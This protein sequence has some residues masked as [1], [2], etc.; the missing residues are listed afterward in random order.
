MTLASARFSRMC[1]LS[2]AFVRGPIGCE[3]SF[4]PFPKKDVVLRERHD[5]GLLGLRPF[6]LVVA[7]LPRLM[8]S[9]CC[10][11]LD[12]SEASMTLVRPCFVAPTF[13]FEPELAVPSR[14][15]IIIVF[16]SFVCYISTLLARQSASGPQQTSAAG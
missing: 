5:H 8:A 14:N 1:L 10:A 13:C 2:A 7:G 4:E 16:V 15:A 11:Q 12:L 6:D 3:R 9:A